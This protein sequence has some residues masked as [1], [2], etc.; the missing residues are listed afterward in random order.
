[1]TS[2]GIRQEHCAKAWCSQDFEKVPAFYAK[3]GSISV[4][5]RLPVL[6]SPRCARIHTR[7]QHVV[8]SKVRFSGFGIASSTN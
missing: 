1:M 7:F 8:I 2:E 3:S 6:I 5:R 4:N